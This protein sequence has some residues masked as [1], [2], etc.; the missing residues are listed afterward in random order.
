MRKTRAK[1]F[2]PGQAVEVVPESARFIQDSDWVPATYVQPLDWE[3]ARMW[4]EVRTSVRTLYVP[5]SRI[6]SV[7]Q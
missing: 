3:S 4:H 1:R 2:E 7:R 6:R 5:P